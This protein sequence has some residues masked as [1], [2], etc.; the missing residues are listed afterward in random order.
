M[1]SIKQ[2]LLRR[3]RDQ[4]IPKHAALPFMPEAPVIVEAGAHVGTD[5]VELAE[6]WPEGTIHAFEPIPAVYE[7][8]VARVGRLSNVR[9]YNVA[10]GA[11][12]GTSTMW[13]SEGGDQSS[14]LSAPKTHLTAYP[15]IRFERQTTVQVTTL[16]TWAAKER[17]D[18]VD[19]LW[20][21]MQGH[22]LV[23]LKHGPRMLPLVKAMIIEVF[24]E[25]LYEGAPLWP[26][27]R[28]WLVEQ[29]F[30]VVR[31]RIDGPFGNALVAR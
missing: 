25:E 18:R 24:A 28:D 2:A 11:S 31:M 10:L 9:V 22:E 4:T 7:Q 16:D 12:T 30:R 19:F 13:V 23:A 26:E 17:I 14:S 29:G 3:L 5:T 27:V 15:D 8:L 6:L 21:D 20:L 1:R